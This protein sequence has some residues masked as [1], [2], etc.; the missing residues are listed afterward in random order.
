[1][2]LD[3]TPCTLAPPAPHTQ[4]TEEALKEQALIEGIGRLQLGIARGRI[5]TP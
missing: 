5:P 4:E 3:E 2:D 1:M